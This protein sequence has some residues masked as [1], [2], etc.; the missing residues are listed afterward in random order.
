MA[1]NKPGSFRGD[2]C[3]LCKWHFALMGHPDVD[4]NSISTQ[5][6]W[7]CIP[8]NFQGEDAKLPRVAIKMS[9]HGHC[10]MFTRAG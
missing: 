3:C 6:G 2:C 4:G 5:D 9:A 7:I 1:C 10:E 8:P